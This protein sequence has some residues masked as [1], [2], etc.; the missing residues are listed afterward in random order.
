M[1]YLEILYN[2]WGCR[3]AVNFF[4]RLTGEIFSNTGYYR[5]FTGLKDLLKAVK[6][7]VVFS[8]Y[9]DAGKCDFVK[10]S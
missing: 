7:K 2:Y 8:K 4:G 6:N 5:Q 9:W 10:V 3:N 1:N